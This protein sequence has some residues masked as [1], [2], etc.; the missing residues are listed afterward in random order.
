VT[1]V[2][3]DFLMTTACASPPTSTARPPICR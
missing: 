2:R 1:K 3:R